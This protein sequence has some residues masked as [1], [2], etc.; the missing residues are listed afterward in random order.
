M[1]LVFHFI[2]WFHIAGEEN[3]LNILEELL[4]EMKD[5]I[6]ECFQKALAENKEME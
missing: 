4:T 2:F 5:K 6:E 3:F 1:T